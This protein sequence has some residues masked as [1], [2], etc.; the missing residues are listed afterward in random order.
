[1]EIKDPQTAY[2]KRKKKLFK[3]WYYLTILQAAQY[4]I[5]FIPIPYLV[6]ILS[7]EKFGLTAFAVAMSQFF[8]VFVEYGFSY[9]AVKTIALHK[10]DKNKVT[11]IYSCAII[12]K[13]LI[14][15]TLLFVFLVLIF[16]VPKISDEKPLFAFAFSIVF[17]DI[18]FT[19]WFFQGMEKMKYIAYLNVILESL[20]VAAIFIFIRRESDYL[21]VPLLDALCS[22]II[23]V[24]SITIIYKKFGIRFKLQPLNRIIFQFKRSWHYFISDF[25]SNAYVSA[26]VFILGFIAGNAA[27]GYY[28]AALSI[29]LPIKALFEP[30]VQ[31]AYPYMSKIANESK[32]KAVYFLRTYSFL[33]AVSALFA[34][35]VLFFGADFIVR[36]FLG[37][38]YAESAF[39]LKIISPV[40]FLYTLNM[41]FCMHVMYPF[42]MKVNFA[43]ITAWAA[44]ISFALIP[45]VAI[46]FKDAG[47]AAIMTAGELYISI[48]AYKYI[49]A[50]GFIF[51]TNPTKSS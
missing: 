40:S 22:L 31:A 2:D 14:S 7:P 37:A 27:V 18:F 51:F 13:A 10:H 4:V 23:G 39:I 25:A 30:V 5:P 1:M 36:I 15:F 17:A 45:A 28:R 42:G 19:A 34:S 50:K 47:M 8:A 11:E 33:V 21:Y 38:E 43:K 20:Y 16:F 49:R 6:R 41:I 35:I 26:S 44:I 9:S 46:P 3:N 24:A 12:I 29:L 32:E 48:M